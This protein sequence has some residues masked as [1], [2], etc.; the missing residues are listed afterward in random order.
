[1]PLDVLQEPTIYCCVRP[2]GHSV[3][4]HSKQRYATPISFTFHLCVTRHNLVFSADF[5][6]PPTSGPP[7][8]SK[9]IL[10]ISPLIH[11]HKTNT[12][13]SPDGPHPTSTPLLIIPTMTLVSQLSRS[14]KVGDGSNP[15]KLR[16]KEPTFI[17][18]TRPPPPSTTVSDLN[19]CMGKTT[20]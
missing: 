19:S 17:M 14:A 12:T 13:T 16:K 3:S 15:R 18:V 5:S 9:T 1:M 10:Q 11:H 6:I 20:I 2:L 8:L 7:S 4:R